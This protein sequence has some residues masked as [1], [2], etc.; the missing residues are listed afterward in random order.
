MRSERFC[1]V[2]NSLSK[3]SLRKGGC[4][5]RQKKRQSALNARYWTFR[6][7]LSEC[8]TPPD[9]TETVGV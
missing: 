1:V 6:L 5:G 2:A 7:K 3:T 8:V 9:V 4:F